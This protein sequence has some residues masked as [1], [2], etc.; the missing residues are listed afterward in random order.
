MAPPPNPVT[1]PTT[2][3]GR[4]ARPRPK[5][6]KPKDAKADANGHRYAQS[7]RTQA[8]NCHNCLAQPKPQHESN[9]SHTPKP[10]TFDSKAGPGREQRCHSPH[11]Q[12][13]MPPN[14]PAPKAKRH[15]TK[16][17]LTHTRVHQDAPAAPLGRD[18][19]Q[20][21]N[22]TRQRTQNYCTAAPA[23]RACA[24]SVR[25]PP[26]FPFQKRNTEEEKKKKIRGG[27]GGTQPPTAHTHRT[28]RAHR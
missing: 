1:Q 22:D 21:T 11:P 24:C 2:A 13:I 6:T 7:H 19:P 4:H 3:A 23:A 5:D 16:P 26:F 17:N 12:P 10:L 18:R 25:V 27:G 14:P 9:P 28:Q 15:L 20:S 8:R